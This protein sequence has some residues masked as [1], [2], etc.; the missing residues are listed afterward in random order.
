MRIALLLAAAVAVAQ[1]S[2]A[3][4]PEQ[5]AQ[6]ANALPH[7]AEATDRFA[8]MAQQFLCHETLRQR[9]VSSAPARSG[10]RQSNQRQIVS[11]YAFTTLKGSSAIREIR[12]ILTVDN[13]KRAK[14]PEGRSFLRDALLAHNDELKNRLLKQFEEAGLTGVPTDL[15]Q[16]VLLFGKSSIKNYAFVFD[17]EET[18]GYTRAL[19]VR[20]EQMKG[21]EGVRIIERGKQKKETLH[22]WLWLRLPDYLPVRI[23]MITSRRDGKHEIRDEAEVDYTDSQKALLPTE[24]IHRRYEDDSLTA[25]DDFQYSNWQLIA[26]QVGRLWSP[27]H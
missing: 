7:L 23:T 10:P 15:G 20:Y 21:P 1:S 2:R 25:E 5:D 19:V 3:A 14:D 22:G 16:L 4:T 13:E 17:R 26:A 12:E 24:V 27:S 8:G 9:T 6:V 18:Q 11:Y